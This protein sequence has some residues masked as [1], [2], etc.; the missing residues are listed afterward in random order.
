VV[1]TGAWDPNL[2]YKDKRI[3][4]IGNGSSGI[5]AFGALQPDAKSITHYIRHSTWIS[6]NYMAQFT[7]NGANFQY[8]DEEKEAFKDPAKLFEYR[9][10]LERTSNGIFKN[11]VFNETCQDVKKAFRANIEKLM[12]ERLHNDEVMMTKLIPSYQ[13]WCRRLTPGDDYLDALQASN[14][15]LV[16]D[17]ITEITKTGV[18]TDSVNEHQD[19]DILILAT[20]FRNNRVPPW[21]MRGKDDISISDLWAKNPDAYLSVAVPQMPNYFT[22]GCGPN[23]TIA[24]GPL[25]SALGFMADYIFKWAVK[26]A[27]EGIKSIIVKS[28]VTE[29]WNVYIQEIMKRTAWNDSGCGSWYKQGST[30]DGYRTGITAI[31]PGSMNHFREMLS[32]IRGEDFEIEYLNPVN[33]W[34]QIIGNGLTQRDAMEGG[35]LAPYLESTFKGENMV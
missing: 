34:A 21:T 17:P 8:S 30:E 35:D 15:A 19:L 12:R 24:N 1:H 25:L 6:M 11:L 7:P 10:K 27:G 2:D 3:G 9:I 22:I 28:D 29:A 32:E 13:P 4:V 5:Q 16:D 23:F 20:G 26:M 33:K 18:V 14:A 31:Y